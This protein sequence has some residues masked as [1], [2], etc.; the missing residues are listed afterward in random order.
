MSTIDETL[1]DDARATQEG[2][3]GPPADDPAGGSDG[4]TGAGTGAQGGA[5]DDAGET[6]EPPAPPAGA[7]SAFKKRCPAKTDGHYVVIYRDE[8]GDGGYLEVGYIEANDE[9]Q[10][11]RLA[12]RDQVWGPVLD[13]LAETKKG[14]TIRAIPARNWRKG[15]PTI[16]AVTKKLR[17]G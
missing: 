3:D 2:A 15:E 7:K 16:Y 11:K 6:K 5:D 9:H 12:M 8:N 14:V 10:A 4:N 17:I 1:E 13:A